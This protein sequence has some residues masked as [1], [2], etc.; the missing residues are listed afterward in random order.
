ME[1]LDKLNWRYATKAMNGQKISQEKIDNLKAF[2]AK[3]IVCPTN[4][5]PE[6][7]RSYYSEL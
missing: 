1:L 4:V 3:V 5:E 2:G 7:P 6:D